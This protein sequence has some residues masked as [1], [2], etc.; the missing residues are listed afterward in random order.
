[1]KAKKIIRTSIILSTLCIFVLTTCSKDTALEEA[2]QKEPPVAETFQLPDEVARHLTEEELNEI[3]F[4]EPPAG[5]PTP[6]GAVE[7]R[8]AK[9]HYWLAWGN[10]PNET[11]Y[12]VVGN[13]T[14]FEVPGNICFDPADCPDPSTWVGQYADAYGDFH[15]IDLR[16]GFRLRSMTHHF[17]N[18]IC[19]GAGDWPGFGFLPNGGPGLAQ[20]RPSTVPGEVEIS[21]TP[22]LFQ[23]DAKIYPCN[24]SSLHP[25]CWRPSTGAYEDI[26]GALNWKFIGDPDELLAQGIFGPPANA[27]VVVW[28]WVYY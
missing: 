15:F 14:P 4:S 12:A 25:L 16:H 11:F 20:F 1:M 24:S 28:G 9:W 3:Y 19:S 6:D 10:L 22:D 17:N 13:C 2:N 18:I 8:G 5:L 7:Q 21:V 26:Q 27:F 23:I